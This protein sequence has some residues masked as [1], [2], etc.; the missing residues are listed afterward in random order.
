MGSSQE[1]DFDVVIVGAGHGG[2]Q[3]AAM[4]RQGKFE[5][6]IAIIGEEPELPYDRPP[7]SKEYFAGEKEFER[8]LLRPEKFWEERDIT[9]LLGQKVA[10]VSADEHTVQTEDNQ[11]IKYGK[12]VWSTGGAPRKLPIPGGNLPNVFGI[13]TKADTD[14]MKAV[15]E[16]SENVVII[17]GGYIGLEA[18]AVLRKFG[19]KVTV[20]EAMDRVL[21][22]VAGKDISHFYQAQHA[23][24]GVD[25]RLNAKIE[26]I[27]GD[28]KAAGVQLAG[29]ETLDADFVIVGIGI[30]P[31]IEPLLEAG[32]KCSNG[33][34][35]NQFCETSLPDVYAIG[36]C[37]AHTNKYAA[38]ETIR[39]ES[40]Q[41][42]NDQG[43]AVAKNIC[44]TQ[45]AY[46]AIPW[47]WSNQ[48]DL[49]LQTI[50]LST[51]HDETV[52]RGD[53]Q[54][55]SF[56]VAY[57]K[58]GRIIALDCVNATKDFAQGKMLIMKNATPD[59]TDL[60]NSEI[61]LKSF[62]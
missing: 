14:A 18:A 31:A 17:G 34:N 46:D 27:T 37:A 45:T 11:K 29:G 3:V 24:H 62:L 47:F 41:N 40:V 4:L 16:T 6:S 8:I 1:L 30:N 54:T 48:Y 36:D 2:A 49:R 9:M 39:L 22:R 13:R 25:I 28:D 55:K 15:S 58:M 19:K 10:Q 61:E 44:G 26:K 59:P 7:L 60:A 35:V 32:A 12:L 20:L 57:L 51:G 56:S 5:G 53:P 33:V 50:G 42:A 23:E 52:L 38:N 21:A 43:R